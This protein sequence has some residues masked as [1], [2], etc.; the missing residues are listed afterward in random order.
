MNNLITY[1]LS[2]Q[3]VCREHVHVM[4]TG[5]Y[6]AST[7]WK[8]QTGYTDLQNWSSEYGLRFSHIASQTSVLFIIWF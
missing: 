6:T 7:L 4:Q 3:T 2:F 1:E 5:Q 8:L